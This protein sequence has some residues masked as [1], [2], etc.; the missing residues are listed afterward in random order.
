VT[1]TR[2]SWFS[3]KILEFM[4][5]QVPVI[6]S[7]TKIDRYYFNEKMGKFLQA[8]ENRDPARC[9]LELIEDDECQAGR[10]RGF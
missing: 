2:K 1:R 10:A 5:L 6:V 3:T 8:G 7:N 9:I 4:A